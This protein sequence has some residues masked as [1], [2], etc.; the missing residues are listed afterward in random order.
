MDDEIIV[1][2]NMREINKVINEIKEVGYNIEDRSN[3]TDYI[4]INFKYLDEITLKLTQPQLTQ[5]VIEDSKV[6]KKYFM[7]PQIP[8]KSNKF[9]KRL[10][11]SKSYDKNWHYRSLI[12]KLDFLEKMI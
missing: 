11:V 2:K 10:K 1:D 9:L 4:G 5:Q 6:M 7:I 3:I 8:S 12:K